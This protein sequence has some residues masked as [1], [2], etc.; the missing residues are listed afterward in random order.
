LQA[1]IVHLFLVIVC[2]PICNYAQGS[3][4]ISIQDNAGQLNNKV[5]YMFTNDSLIVNGVGDYGRSPVSYIHRQLSKKECRKLRTF[6]NSFPID[7]L[8]DVYNFDFTPAS[9]EGK[10]YY[11]RIMKVEI[12]NAGNSRSYEAYNCWVRF[13]SM[14]IQA[15]NPLL[16]Q[17][18]R[19]KY[20]KNNFEK[21]Y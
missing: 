19:I 2:L 5:E 8:D 7:S 1:T 18:V 14:I 13:T 16:P 9:Y 20:D 6:L 10:G 4:M 17:E 11:A 15:V 12:S 3:F 21:F